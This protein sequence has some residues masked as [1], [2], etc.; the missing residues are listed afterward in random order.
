MKKY[1]ILSLCA[2]LLALTLHSCGIAAITIHHYAIDLE[3]VKVNGIGVSQ[4]HIKEQTY[5][6]S[7]ISAKFVFEQEKLAFRI[8]NNTTLPINLIWDRSAF[9]DAADLSYRVTH[10]GVKHVDKQYIQAN[11]VILPRAYLDDVIVPTDY[12]NFSYNKYDMGWKISN[13]LNTAYRH[14]LKLEDRKIRILFVFEQDNKLTPYEFI[15]S[16]EET[17]RETRAYI[18]EIIPYERR[19]ENLRKAKREQERKAKELEK[20]KKNR[21]Q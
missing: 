19:M 6:D 2:V 4:E 13:L 1:Y 11:S 17:D 21:K 18:P 10:A 3:E 5:S 14:D 15:F 8:S 7:T 12:I 9:A 20:A 16:I